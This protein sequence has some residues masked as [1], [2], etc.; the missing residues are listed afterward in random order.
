MLCCYLDFVSVYTCITYFQKTIIYQ[1]DT[2]SNKTIFD[3]CVATQMSNRTN[4]QKRK[5]CDD[6]F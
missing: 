2:F 6:Q 1:V 5:Q 4:K 3:K